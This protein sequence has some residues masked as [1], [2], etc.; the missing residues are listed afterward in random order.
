MQILVQFTFYN[1]RNQMEEM[2]FDVF[3]SKGFS[4][5]AEIEVI[6]NL[7]RTHSI[8]PAFT[9]IKTSVVSSRHYMVS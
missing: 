7:K 8:P 2:V 3:M 4:H 5:A 6:A 1:P 9:A